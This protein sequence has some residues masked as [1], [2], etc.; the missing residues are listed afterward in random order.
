MAAVWLRRRTELRAHWEG[1][2]ALVVVLG[3]VGAVV[4]AVATGARRT[5]TAPA[6][7]VEAVGGEGDAHIFDAGGADPGW[8]PGWLAARV[9][10]AEVLRTE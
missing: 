4:L 9:R 10:P 7:L 8:I 6:R 1:T 5:S 3:V 2:L